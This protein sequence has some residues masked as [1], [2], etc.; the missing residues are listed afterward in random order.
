MATVPVARSYNQILGDLL[1]AFLSRTGLTSIRTGSPVLSI[2]EAAAQSDV[3]S[4]QDIFQMLASVSLDNAEKSALDRIA[5]EENTSRQPDTTASGPVTVSDTRYTKISTKVFQG[6]AAP[7]AGSTYLYALDASTFPASGDL[8]IGRGTS[9]YE[10]PIAYASK[11][12]LGT[13]WRFNLSS[14]TQKFHNWNETIIL[15]QGGNRLIAAGTLVQ[16]RLGSTSQPVQFSVLFDA[17]LADGE[18]SL[19]GVTVVATRPGISG[20]VPSGAISEFVSVPFTGATVTNPG[21]FSNALPAEDDKTLRER[22]QNLRQSRSKGTPLAIK[23]AVLGI[24][25]DNKRVASANLVTGKDVATTLVI[26]DGTGYEENSVGIA[27]ET[28]LDVAVGGEQYFQTTLR[29]MTKAFVASIG[30]SPF[31]LVDGSKLAVKVGGVLQ[32]HT[33]NAS[34]FLAIGNSSAYEVVASIN[35]NSTLLFQARTLGNGTQVV[36]EAKGDTNED[37]EVTTVA[38]GKTDANLVLAF[39]TGKNQTSWLYKNDRL[40][41]KDGL[42]P[43][44]M[45]EAQTGWA[46]MTSPMTLA[47]DV[48]G[49]GGV[50]Y[51]FADQ[52]FI[53]AATGYT[54]LASSNSLDAWAKVFN[55]KIVG[56]T[57][58]VSSGRL[59]LASNLGASSRASLEITGGTLVSAGMFVIPSSGLLSE[60]LDKDYALDRNTGQIRTTSAL[61]ADDSLT[62]GTVNSRAFLESTAFPTTTL[63]SDALLWFVV[64]GDASIVP[65]AL[66]ASNTVTFSEHVLVPPFASYKRV[67]ITAN[68]A[69]FTNIQQGDWAVIVDE[70]LTA[71]NRGAFRVS[72]VDAAFNYFEIDRS[73]FVADAGVAM[74][75]GGIVF[76]RTTGLVQK[77]VVPAGADY[78]AAT[79]VAAF[80]KTYLKYKTQV[81]NFTVGQI[82]TG[83]TSGATGTIVADADAGATGTLTLTSV[84]GAFIDGENLTDPLGGAAVAN[85]F[86]TG[87][88]SA[89]ASV[90]RTNKMRIR[91]DS[92]AS[93][94]GIALVAQNAEAVKLGFSIESRNNLVNHLPSV[95]SQN[96][97]AG[98]PIDFIIKAI[99]GVTSTTRFTVSTASMNEASVLKFVKV[100]PDLDNAAR[101]ERYGDNTGMRTLVQGM[102]TPITVRTAANHE[103]LAWDM[104][105]ACAPFGLTAQDDLSVLLDNDTAQHNYSFN[106]YRRVKPTTAVYGA[107]NFYTDTDNAGAT[108]ATGF[109]VGFEWNDFAVFMK[110]RAKS[111]AEAGDT[112]KTVLW[113]ANRFGPDGTYTYVRYTY[114]T[115]ASQALSCLPDPTENGYQSR[116]WANVRLPSGATRTGWTVRNTTWVG[117]L[118]T[119]AGALVTLSFFLGFPI[120]SAT[121]VALLDFNTQTVNFTVGQVVTGGTSGATGVIAS[122]VD[123]GA[124][125]TLTLT[126]VVGNFQAAEALTDPLGGAAVAT[127]PQVGQTNLTLTT[128]GFN[129]GLAPGDQIWVQSTDVNFTT[130]LKTITTAPS[131]TTLTYTENTNTVAATPNIGTISRDTAGEATLTGSNVIV[132][133][134]ANISAPAGVGAAYKG[135]VKIGTLGNQTW[136]GLADVATAVT[137]GTTVNWYRLYDTAAL[138]FF[139]LQSIT[140]AGVAAAVNA[141]AVLPGS[142]CPVTAVAVGL[143]GV[144]TGVIDTASYEEFTATGYGYQLKDGL[145]WVLSHNTPATP[146]TNT[147]LTF[148][149]AIEASLATN[150]DWANEEVR[151]VP[152]SARNSA[153][154][155]NCLAVSGLASG[156]E[157]EYTESGA[158]QISSVTPGSA[159]SVQVLGGK[160]NSVSATVIG[161]AMDIDSVR[162]MVQV[163]AAEAEGLCAGQWVDVQNTMTAIKPV[164][165]AATRCVS[166]VAATRTFLLDTTKVWDYANTAAAAVNGFRYQI[167]NFGRYQYFLFDD[168]LYG[169]ATPSFLGVK[170]GDYVKISATGSSRNSGLFRIVR[171]SNANKHFWI[172]N[173]NGF[174]ETSTANLWFLT[175]NSLLPGDTVHISTSLWGAGNRGVWTVESLDAGDQYKFTVTGTPADFTGPV[176]LGTSA[177]LVQAVEGAPTKLVKQIYSVSINPSSSDYCDVK[178]TTVAGYTR[179]GS[180]NGSYLRALDKLNFSTS[181]VNGVDGYRQST[182][183]IEESNKVLYGDEQDPAT[184]PGVVAAGA[185]VNISG[186]KVKRVTLA[187]GLRVRSGITTSAPTE[188]FNRVRSVVATVIN[189]SGVGQPIAISSIVAAAES[190]NGVVAVTILSPSYGVGNDLITAQPQEK[191]MILTPDTDI[192]INLVG[193]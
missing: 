64:D 95:L 133:D 8:Y 14:G 139:P 102:G 101:R 77:V 164:F 93:T 167:K 115:E 50:T 98:T 130:G 175:A 16:T 100:F 156:A 33:F 63:A 110:A 121:R 26:D 114:P 113:R 162:M 97:E 124:T 161:S 57:A 128:G 174:D 163:P 5:A 59:L 60:G 150:S 58:T 125:G 68:A 78:T 72:Y 17:T 129:H 144:A 136:S 12:N 123:A 46:A 37:I 104:L 182:G 49:T 80:S 18:T 27:Q 7:I 71:S 185:T 75:A 186:P 189:R 56:V 108:L 32:E 94:A 96:T 30:T 170:E 120:A 188:V 19:S 65:T 84:L 67:R 92:F 83:A 137:P 160:A 143:A 91:T 119:A 20:N 52:D 151:L 192:Q 172:E 176:A 42:I 165:T 69:C 171:I 53:D 183:L 10:G 29:P 103:F 149:A 43:R 107:A 73:S 109:G 47:I 146:A 131:G 38:L 74:S 2:L 126:G 140:A 173:P 45:S 180:V 34:D 147:S 55:A 135:S 41:Y 181:I 6:V 112:T 85:G 31:V 11:T 39:P 127:A 25:A 28:L 21:P 177:Q 88:R 190:V 193:E 154:F 82:V 86:S 187:L 99:T 61:L 158:V 76:V 122:Q 70:N 24:T 169:G 87:L 36:L 90:Y 159:G 179:V 157:V 48:D 51:S 184:Y 148:K 142:V 152:M 22:I 79:V 9:N 23:T 178:L 168:T 15:A 138:K 191:L 4:S 81:G 13:Y 111:H 89:T 117:R 44:L 132:G 141:L 153:D 35:A 106:T 1:D 105:V 54:L 118:A 145:N 3:R 40:M 166:V 134:I 155:L 62:L 116:T 66:K